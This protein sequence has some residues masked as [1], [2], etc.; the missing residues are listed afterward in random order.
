M[1]EQPNGNSGATG[2][3]NDPNLVMVPTGAWVDPLL[4]ICRHEDPAPGAWHYIYG[5]YDPRSG[6]LRYVGKTDRPEQ[7]LANQMNERGD[8]HRCHWLQ[9]L[10]SLGL[11]PTQQILTA[12][13]RGDDWQMAERW[14]IA[15]ALHMRDPLTN[16]TDGGD[17][18]CGLSPEAR[19]KMAATWVGRK[20]TPEARARMRS[21]PAQCFTSARRD[22][23]AAKM[24][25]RVFTAEHRGRIRVAIQK[26][27]PTQVREIRVLIDQGVSQYV[28][29]ER[30]GV[31][32][33]T[34]SNI[35]RGVTYRTIS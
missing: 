28:I 12:V 4:A 14:R 3:G 32:Q 9:E 7:R 11:R 13:P 35:A 31:H 29:A 21:R 23:V 22:A 5:L 27:T 16:A 18:V 24:R 25:D 1:Y 17:G 26:L 6:A 20:H 30:F 33:G 8:T 19:A 34:V 10:R 2:S 15:V